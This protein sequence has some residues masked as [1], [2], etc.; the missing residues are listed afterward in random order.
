MDRF[1]TDTLVAEDQAF[2]ESMA[3]LNQRLE[4]LK[5]VFPNARH[6]RAL[7]ALQRANAQLTAAALTV[8]PAPT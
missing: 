8:R 4:A 5:L 1:A 2:V 6:R 3:S 7:E